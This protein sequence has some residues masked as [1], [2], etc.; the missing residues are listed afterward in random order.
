VLNRL[1]SRDCYEAYLSQITAGAQ[2]S[3]NIRL[4]QGGS[5]IYLSQSTRRERQSRKQAN[6]DE[7]SYIAYG[8]LTT[9]GKNSGLPPLQRPRRRRQ[10]AG[11]GAPHPA[12]ASP[13]AT[14]WH[15]HR[16]LVDWIGSA[17][18]A[19]GDLVSEQG[20][21][22]GSC[23]GPGGNGRG[24]TRPEVRVVSCAASWQGR[25]RTGRRIPSPAVRQIRTE[26]KK[27]ARRTA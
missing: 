23:A 21:A 8:Y 24:E 6:R 7:L 10:A 20:Q 5:G 15:A 13:R 1:L 12:T 26:N 17:E 16:A 11:G 3:A 27:C 19:D 9:T 22:G 14:T 4:L 25:C 18:P 2:D